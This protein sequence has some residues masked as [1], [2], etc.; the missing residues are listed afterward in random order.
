MLSTSLPTS[1]LTNPIDN[2]SPSSKL[3]IG[4]TPPG[5]SSST[6]ATSADEAIF[7]NLIGL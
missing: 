2:T 5:T 3:S 7:R 4:N 1:P 6:R